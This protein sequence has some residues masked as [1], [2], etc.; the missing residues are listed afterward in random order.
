MAVSM[1]S[2]GAGV[3]LAVFP[4]VLAMLVVVTVAVLMAVVMPSF[5]A[6]IVV[7][8]VTAGG[9]CCLLQQVRVYLRKQRSCSQHVPS[10]LPRLQATAHGGQRAWPSFSG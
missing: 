10:R 7:M 4:A 8:V 1:L 5:V 6:V 2:A 9:S 3:A